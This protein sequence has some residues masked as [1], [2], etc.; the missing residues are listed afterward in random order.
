MIT[1]TPNLDQLKRAK[2]L[3]DFGT[4]NNSI[5]EGDG[6]A[7]GALAEICFFD[8]FKEIGKEI[9]HSKHY[10]YDFILNQKKIEV[11]AMRVNTTPSLLHHCNLSTH[12]LRQRCDYYC[13]ISVMNDF[14]KVFING[15]ISKKD[16]FDNAVLHLE[17]EKDNNFTYKCDTMTMTIAQLKQLNDDNN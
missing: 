4:L 7:A 2:N 3:Y 13:F 9:I 11:K 14:T 16:F 8:Y 12:N 5:T 17:G 10:D 6:S 1:I 15:Y